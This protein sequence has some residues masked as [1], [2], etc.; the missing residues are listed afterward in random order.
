MRRT[1]KALIRRTGRRRGTAIVEFAVV[2]PLLLVLLFGI[3]DFGWIFMVRQTLTN[4]AREGC[5]VAV[6]QTATAEQVANRVRSVMQPTGYAQGTD[7][8][9][10]TSAIDAEVQWVQ[11]SMPVDRCTLVGFVVKGGY[12]LTGRSSMRKEG[13]AGG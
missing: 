8:T 1:K 3:I 2:L 4:A 11:V 13:V 12:S 5:R 10:T 9:L 7:W 6:L